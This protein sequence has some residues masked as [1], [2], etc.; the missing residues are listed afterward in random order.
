MVHQLYLH[1]RVFSTM[2]HFHYLQ[3]ALQF[4]IIIIC[5][6]TRSL[7]SPLSQNCTEC[8]KQVRTTTQDGFQLVFT[9]IHQSQPPTSCT[10]KP[11]CSLNT[12][13][14]YQ[15]FH[16]CILNNKVI[17]HSPSTPKYYNVTLTSGLPKSYM[18]DTIPDGKGILYYVNS[19]KV[20]MG[21]QSSVTLTFDACEAIDKHPNTVKCGSDSWKA[22]YVFNN[23]YLCPYNRAYNPSSWLPCAGDDKLSG[24]SLVCDYT[25]GGYTGCPDVGR[26][27]K[28]TGNTVSLDWPIRTEGSSWQDTWG[29]EIDGTGGDP[30]TYI[31]ITQRRDKPRPIIHRTTIVG[32]QSFFDEVSHLDEELKKHAISHQAK[33]MFVNL[34][35][36]IALSLEVKNCFVCGGTNIGE[37]WPWEAKEIFQSDLNALNTTVTYNRKNS[38]YEW[39]LQTDVIGRQ[40]L[41]RQYSKLYTVP[42]GNSPCT[43]VLTVT[44]DNRTW[45]QTENL[46]KPASFWTEPSL[47]ATWNAAGKPSTPFIAPDGY[48][49]VCGRRAYEQLP[50]TW[51]GTCFLA[52][53]RPSFFLLLVTA[54]E[55]LGIPIYSP[56]KP[57]KRRRKR[58]DKVSIGDWSDKEWPPERIVQY[59]G[60]ATW[61]EDGS[62]GYRTPIY[63]LNRIIRL[64]AVLELLTNDSAMAL[65]ILAK[66]NTKLITAVYQNRLALDYLLAQEGGVC[67]KFNLS[68]CCLQIDDKSK[69]IE[70]ITDRMV[71][72]AHVPVQTWSGAFDWTTSMP[73]WISSIPGLKELFFPLIFFL[74]SCA[75]FPLCFPLLLRNLR[76]MM[77][78]IADRR[79]AAHIMIMNQYT[80]VSSFPSSDSSDSEA[81][82]SDTNL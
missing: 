78:T 35:K 57:N 72:L 18:S 71:R 12:T 75:I 7:N 81:E 67:G 13:Q 33:N 61:A 22:A 16:R 47:N 42:I 1:H 32:Y 52:T 14:G 46:T 11:A 50:S 69:V 25:G 31:T 6:T 66:Q 73:N 8:I 3:R 30:M 59:Y 56:M 70:E 74:I 64:Q 19:T 44:M 68:N 45:W 39:A 29:F 28:G 49:F 63:M 40:C 27:K 65:N 20:L 48:Y 53:I 51:Y 76:A 77:E 62:Y 43:G 58:Q 79:A 23:K 41:S 10:V 26:L 37:Q 82:Y 38:P 55:T 60:P 17:C 80:S 9:I 5:T 34:A 4:L 54:G 21:G 36:N 2:D 24:W 15:S